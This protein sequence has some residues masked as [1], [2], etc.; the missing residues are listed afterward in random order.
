LY[1]ILNKFARIDYLHNNNF[2]F[3]D[4][5]PENFVV[6]LGKKADMIYII[7]FGLCKKFID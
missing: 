5:K 2:I 6:G 3:R 1:I 7:D 4:L